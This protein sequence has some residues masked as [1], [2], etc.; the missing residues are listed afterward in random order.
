[1]GSEA[2][3][4]PLEPAPSTVAA[5]AREQSRVFPC[6]GCGANLQFDIGAQLLKCPYCAHEQDLGIDGEEDL[7]ERDLIG[8]LERESER[9]VERAGDPALRVVR[10]EDCGAE[11]SFAGTLTSATCPYCGAALQVKDAH[12]A[13]GRIPAD[14]VLPFAVEHDA[15]R[16]CL[17]GW[18][19]SRW[20]APS[21]FR[22]QGV[23]GRFQ[24][25]YLPYWTFDAMTGTVY[26]GE[27]GD[28]YWVTIQTGKQTQRVR[29]T[30]WQSA[31]GSFRRFFDDVLVPGAR[32]RENSLPTKLLAGL[33]PWPL[34][35]SLPFTAAALSGFSA[36]TYDVPL[37]DAFGSG[38]MLM[39]AM[40][41]QDVLRRIG[42]D[43]QRIHA[44]KSDFAALTYKHLL[45]PV[46]LLTYRFRN[47][48]FRVSVNGATG[49]VQGERPWSVW[50]ILGLV[51]VVAGIVTA[52]VVWTRGSG[53][54]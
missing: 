31:S 19:R 5:D 12:V 2:S 33:D 30:R 41:R 42:G 27:R 11:N 15:A 21:G 50:K 17:V 1:M 8:A 13:P 24:G 48:P 44:V 25:V 14:G 28:H 18:I 51:V 9:R 7:V 46:W 37:A 16:E 22:A 32:G 54:P 40:L 20:F 53:A 49:E 35:A 47:K 52:I 6:A 39:D 23:Q 34:E 38:R 36:R 10:C 43:E 29:R 26:R 4:A 3:S 45:L